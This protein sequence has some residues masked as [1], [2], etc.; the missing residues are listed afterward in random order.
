MELKNYQKQVLKD[1]S[2]YL[3]LLNETHNIKTAYLK[4]WNDKDVR[5]GYG[6]MPEYRDTITGTPH[7]CFKVPTGGGKTF[8][9]CASLKPFFE[10]M[11]F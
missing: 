5:V 6:G 8:I 11:P 1:L 10:Q 7:V 9:A 4:H 3:K 2:N